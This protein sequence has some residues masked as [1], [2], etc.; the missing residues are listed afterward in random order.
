M[1]CTLLDC[2]MSIVFRI[3]YRVFDAER[4]VPKKEMCSCRDRIVVARV[5]VFIQNMKTSGSK[6]F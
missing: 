3:D 6:A 1:R 4:Y 5:I 2:A